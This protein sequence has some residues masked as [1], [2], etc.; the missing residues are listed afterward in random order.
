MGNFNVIPLNSTGVEF[1]QGWFYSIRY[2]Q[3]VL[4]I[5]DA[6]PIN[7]T[8][9]SVPVTY[10]NVIFDANSGYGTPPDAMMN[11]VVGLDI[12]LPPAIGLSMNG[13][14]FGGWNTKA[15]GSGKNY[16]AGT[17][18]AVYDKDS[19]NPG[20]IIFYAKWISNIGI[21]SGVNAIA[22]GQS[23]I[24]L[25]WNQVSG[26]D[27]YW[28]YL[29]SSATA[30]QDTFTERR[31]V[32]TGASTSFTD[33]SSSTTYYFKVSAYNH[34]GEGELSEMVYAITSQGTSYQV[35]STI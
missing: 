30:H 35:N 16:T 21:P 12:I 9:T 29:Y 11:Q 5:I 31:Q 17:E 3:H 1:K 27:G 20:D 7:I 14:V 8:N 15:D 32:T 2:S 28:V 18:F 19:V 26:A 13:A 23:S 24:S 10:N 25:T 22:A 6:K 34:I 33:L 4:T